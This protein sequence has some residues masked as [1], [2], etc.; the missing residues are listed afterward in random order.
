MRVLVTGAAGLT[1]GAVV[2]LLADRGDDVLAVVRRPADSAALA[3]AEVA[4]ADCSDVAAMEPLLARCDALVHVAGIHLG[5]Q[6]ARLRGLRRL[7]CA[8]VISSASVASPHRASA[9]IYRAGEDA[10]RSA[11]PETV[12][13]RPTMIYGSARDR[14]VH[15]VIR[16]ARRYRFLPLFGNGASLLQPMHYVDLAAGVARLVAAGC[17]EREPI[18]AG[19]AAPISVRRAGEEIFAALGLPPRFLRLPMAASLGAAG[20]LDAILGSRLTERIARMRE[21]RSVDVTRLIA[22]TGVRPRDFGN[23]VRDEVRELAAADWWR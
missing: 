13:V 10:I 12:I 15:H 6:I 16:F 18:S 14:N 11:R 20:V 17:S 5:A 2:R 23:G 3:D 1:A 21:D 4:V 19:G 9:A 22:L 7:S 8:V